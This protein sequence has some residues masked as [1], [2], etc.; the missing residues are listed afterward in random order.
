MTRN[1]EVGPSGMNRCYGF[2]S[3]HNQQIIKKSDWWA[4][5]AIDEPT[6]FENVRFNK[7]D[8]Q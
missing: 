8:P 2:T 3:T 6:R 5:T 7:L 4:A 1:V